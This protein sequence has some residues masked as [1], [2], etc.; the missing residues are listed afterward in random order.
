MLLRSGAERRVRGM[1]IGAFEQRSG[2]EN[3]RSVSCCVRYRE[4]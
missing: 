2:A 1:Y 4:V 3:E